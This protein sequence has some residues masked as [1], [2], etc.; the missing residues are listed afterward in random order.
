MRAHLGFAAAAHAQPVGVIVVLLGA[1]ALGH[2]WF[3]VLLV[4]A[5][6][7]APAATL[8]GI[9]VFTSPGRDGGWRSAY[10]GCGT[11]HTG[12]PRGWCPPGRR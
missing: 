2:V 8:T 3:G 5:Y 4:L 1:L 6:G 11:G 10:P 7:L 12:F 9:G